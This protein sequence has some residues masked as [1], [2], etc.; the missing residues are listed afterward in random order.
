MKRKLNK[1]ELGM[2]AKV[3]NQKK[4]DV[5][6]LEYQIKYYDLMIEEGVRINYE[7]TLREYKSKKKVFEE[8]LSIANQ[9][10]KITENQIKV[11]VE[12]RKDIVVKEDK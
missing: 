6:W 2:A 3:I 4:K 9:A 10:I 1:D 11:G 8:E 7:K 5:E 12:I